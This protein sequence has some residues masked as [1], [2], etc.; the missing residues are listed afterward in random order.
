MHPPPGRWARDETAHINQCWA[1]RCGRRDGGHVAA[2]EGQR[3]LA[4][5]H[6][7]RSPDGGRGLEQIIPKDRDPGAGQARVVHYIVSNSPGTSGG[8]MRIYRQEM[9]SVDA[10][11]REKF[12][13]R[14]VELTPEQLLRLCR[15]IQHGF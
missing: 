14:F 1:F 11:S 6:D 15:G 8:I 9:A 13:K 3:P 7:R 2:L 5:L 10:S 4:L 12:S